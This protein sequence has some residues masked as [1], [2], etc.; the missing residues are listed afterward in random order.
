[1]ETKLSDNDS[2]ENENINI[3]S[4]SYIMLCSIKEFLREQ[5]KNHLC[6]ALLPRVLETEKNESRSTRNS[7]FVE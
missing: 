2:K 5:K 6:L 1:V 7:T 4:S 3:C